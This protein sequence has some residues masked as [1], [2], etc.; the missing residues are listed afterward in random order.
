MTPPPDEDLLRARQRSRSIAT[1]LVLAGLVILFF[2]L[3]IAK[4]SGR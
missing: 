4:M 2:L 3:T 1:A